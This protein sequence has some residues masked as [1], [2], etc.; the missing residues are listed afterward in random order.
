MD[1]EPALWWP[2]E[3]QAAVLNEREKSGYLARRDDALIARH[4]KY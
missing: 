4:S 1:Y 3:D 2:V